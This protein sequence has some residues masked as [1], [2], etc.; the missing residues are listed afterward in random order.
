MR[1]YH[2]VMY[3]T[4]IVFKAERDG[5]YQRCPNEGWDVDAES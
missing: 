1:H 2:V 5:P 4:R 3:F